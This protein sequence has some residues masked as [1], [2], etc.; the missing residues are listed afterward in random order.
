MRSRQLYRLFS[1]LTDIT[2]LKTTYFLLNC[3]YT[4]TMASGVAE[5]G[6]GKTVSQV[7]LTEIGSPILY[8]ALLFRP[9]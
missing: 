3:S 2:T 1:Q 9:R 5:N 7:F 8:F 6:C 4:T